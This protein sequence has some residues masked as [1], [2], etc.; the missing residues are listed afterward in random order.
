MAATALFSLFDGRHGVDRRV[1]WRAMHHHF[2]T[3][4]CSFLMAQLHFRQVQLQLQNS[5]ILHR[6]GMTAR[7]L[8]SLAQAAQQGGEGHVAPH[9]PSPAPSPTVDVAFD[10]AENGEETSQ[11][12]P[13]TPPFTQAT[14]NIFDLSLPARCPAVTWSLSDGNPSDGDTTDDSASGYPVPDLTDNLDPNPDPDSDVSDPALNTMDQDWPD[15]SSDPDRPWH[16]KG[17]YDPVYDVD[18]PVF[19][20]ALFFAARDKEQKEEGTYYSYTNHLTD[21]PT[22]PTGYFGS[23]TSNE[24]YGSDHDYGEDFWAL[25]ASKAQARLDTFSAYDDRNPLP[26]HR[27]RKPCFAFQKGDCDRGDDCRFWH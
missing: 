4:M 6:R 22:P 23:D 25:R 3:A 13:K 26:D 14:K 1:H 21:C 8:A 9:T 10:S 15:S 20:S 11:I 27:S 18:S 17:P 12:A 19:N 16:P 7:L 5:Y 2:R 24:D